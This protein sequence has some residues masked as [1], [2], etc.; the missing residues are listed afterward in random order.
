MQD[1]TP[2]TKRPRTTPTVTPDGFDVTQVIGRVVFDEAGDRS[3]HEAA[4]CVIARHDTPGDYTFPLPNGDTCH[5]SVHYES[6][7][8]GNGDPVA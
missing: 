7:Y 5:V 6:D 4:F 3:P 8:K 2:R 1:R